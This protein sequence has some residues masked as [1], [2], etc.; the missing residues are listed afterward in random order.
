MI[1]SYIFIF[2]HL[3]FI[4]GHKNIS[5]HIFLQSSQ[6]EFDLFLLYE[7]KADV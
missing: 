6:F 7:L 5:S 4:F 3:L 2:G 1:P